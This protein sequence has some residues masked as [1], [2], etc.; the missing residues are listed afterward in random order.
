MPAATSIGM[1]P[2]FDGQ[3]RAVEAFVLDAPD[4]LDLYDRDV[5]LDFVEYV[6]SERDFDSAEALVEQ[7]DEDV[8][9]VRDILSGG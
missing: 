1:R 6:R 4:S 5:S 8:R 9:Q 3:E 2:T 7:M